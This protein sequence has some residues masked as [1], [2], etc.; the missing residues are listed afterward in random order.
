MRGDWDAFAEHRQHVHA[1]LC[2]DAPEK[3]LGILGAGH[4]ND[5]DRCLLS[6]QYPT[7]T[8]VDLDPEASLERLLERQGVEVR[9]PVD[10]SGVLTDIP[11]AMTMSDEL[12]KTLLAKAGSVRLPKLAT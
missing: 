3:S 7:V 11:D 6:R 4:A 9:S 12:F 5:I 8:P 2:N 10:R 1:L